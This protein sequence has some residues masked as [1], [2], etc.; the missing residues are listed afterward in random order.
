[1]IYDA[2]RRI[3]T[4]VAWAL[5]TGKTNECYWQVF[6][7][8]TFVVQDLDPSQIGI[9]FELA[10]FTNVSIYFPEAKLIGCLFH[11]KQAIHRK[12]K[13][14]KFPDKEVDY[15]MRRGVIDLLTVIPLK[16]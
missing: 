4:P 15:A 9:D 11:F 16:H 12:M 1:M 5:M 10:F 14:L 13:K 7:W 3:Y 2:G 8:I 6:N